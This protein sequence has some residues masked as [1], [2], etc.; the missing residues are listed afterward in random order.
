MARIRGVFLV[1]CAVA[2]L[3]RAAFPPPINQRVAELLANMTVEEKIAQLWYGGA[4]TQNATDLLALMPHGIGTL[5]LSSLAHRNEI[6]AVFMKSTRLG[7]PVSF[8]GE[9]LHSAGVSN[10]T[11]F[12][13]PSLVGC[14][15]NTS[16]SEAIGR[17]IAVEA[18]ANG[19]DRSFSPV[20]QVTTDPRWGRVAENFGEDALLVARMGAAATI[21]LLV[22]RGVGV[23]P[24]HGTTSPS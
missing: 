7:V 11:I 14:S 9:T 20:L 17:T 10:V 6:Q 4:P 3:A 12:P 15:W 24:N 16:L 23:S 5:E 18:W 21:G 22:R 13:T 2:C 8:Y 19:I 1:A